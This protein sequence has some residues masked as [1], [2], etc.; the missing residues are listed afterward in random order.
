MLESW[1][2]NSQNQ[3][4][5]NFFFMFILKESLNEKRYLMKRKLNF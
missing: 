1:Y 5:S 3:I 2:E 4:K